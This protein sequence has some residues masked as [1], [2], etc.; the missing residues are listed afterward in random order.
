MPIEEP[1]EFRNEQLK[2]LLPVLMLNAPPNDASADNLVRM[3]AH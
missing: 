1:E 3:N 2:P